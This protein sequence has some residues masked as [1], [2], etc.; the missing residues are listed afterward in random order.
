[1]G[2]IDVRDEMAARAVVVGGKGQGRHGRAQVRTADADVDHIRDLAARDG[3]LAGADTV[4]K[5][6]HP[7]EGVQHTGHDILAVDQ[8]WIAGEV[9]KRRV[10]NRAALGFVDLGTCEHRVA[11]RGHLCLFVHRDQQI[12]A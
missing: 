9:A 7:F 12:A 5:G 4:G 2:P 10:Q 6:L 11:P 8:N 3:D 1:M